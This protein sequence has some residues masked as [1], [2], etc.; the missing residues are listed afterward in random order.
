MTLGTKLFIGLATVLIVIMLIHGYLSVEQ[1]RENVRREMRVGMTALSR[2]IQAALRYTYGDKK[3]LLSTSGFIDGVAPLGN[4]HGIIVYEPSGKPVATSASLK[5]INGYSPLDPGPILNIDPRPVIFSGRTIDGYVE[6]AAHPVYFRVEPIFDSDGRLAGAFVLGRRGLGLSQSIDSRRRRIIIT[7]SS[8]VIVLGFLTFVLV[9]RNISR[10]IDELIQRIREIGR[11]DWDKRI[12]MKGRDELS[13]LAGEFNQLCGRLQE[14]YRRL[15]EEQQE[16]S[17][18]E[19]HLRQSERLASVG[20]L[21]AGLAHEIGTPLN[22]IG[23]RAEYLL[24]RARTQQ[25][26][27]ENLEI[28]RSQIDRIAG[29]VRQLLEFSRRREPALRTVAVMPLLG[30]VISLIDHKIEEK[31]IHVELAGLESVPAVRGDP[32]LLQQVFINLF[33]N[34]L[35]A[36]QAGGS[37]TISG[38]VTSNGTGSGAS[39]GTDVWVR[40]AFEDN[41]RGIAPE[42]LGRVFDPFFTTKDVGEGTGLGLAVTYGIVKEHGGDILVESEAGQFARFIILLPAE[43]TAIDSNGGPKEK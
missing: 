24:R 18:L 16:R 2:S 9:R 39:A 4:T 30:K 5:Q 40:I 34:S 36:L 11:G 19:S 14:T 17:N 37:I 6:A 3:D 1:D 7:T 29:I 28:I 25:E 21:A 38:D 20:Q 10:P 8:L 41:G 27:T 12:D 35:H 22:I 13:S 15:T 43:K 32:D 42:M 31:R 33:L 26:L 23:G